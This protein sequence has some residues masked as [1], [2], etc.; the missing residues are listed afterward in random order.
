MRVD[1]N[2]A[3]RM[4]Q[5]ITYIEKSHVFYLQ[6][7]HISYIF[8]A[9]E[10]GHLRHFY[11]GEKLPAGEDLSFYFRDED[12]GFSGNFDGAKD[13]TASMDTAFLEYPT[14]EMGDYRRPAVL[15]IMPGGARRTDFTY[16]SYRILNE[17]PPLDGLPHVRCGETLEITLRDDAYDLELRLCYTV[18][19]DSDA[20]VRSAKLTNRSAVPV[21]IEKIS[22]FSL[23]FIDADFETI[24]LYGRPCCERMPVREKCAPGYHDFSS[25]FRGSS[26][27]YLNPFFALVRRETG[28]THGEA[29]GFALVYSGAF[30]LS[31]EL[32]TYGTLRVQGGVSDCD[33]SWLLKSGE[34][35]QTPEA[36]L[37][38][39]GEGL[40]GMSRA[41]HALWRN[42]LMPPRSL[43]RRRPVVANSW[44]AAYFDFDTEKLFTL[45]DAAAEC[46][47]DTF[48]LDDG[49][50]ESR[51]NDSGGLGDW[52]ADT[53]KLHGG[54][55]AIAVRCRERGLSFGL[56]FEPEMV[57]E[58]SRLYRAHP[59]WCLKNPRSGPV[60]GRNQLVLD[61]CNPAV[62][63]CIY[64][65]MTRAIDISGANY[66][67]WDMNRYL[68]DLYA[69]SLPPERQQ[70]VQHRYVL[71]VYSLAE[72]LLGRFP[73]LLIEGCSGGGGRFDAGMLF[74][75]AQIWTSDNTDAYERATIQYG[76]SLC[77]PPSAM[78]AH[79][80]ACPNHLT[81][82]T[83]PPAAR[84]AVASSCAFGYEL[85]LAALSREER[86]VLKRQTEAYRET[87]PLVL[88][89][90]MFRLAEMRRDGLFAVAL[91][92]AGK[93]KAYIA[94]ITGQAH[95]NPLQKRLKIIGLDDGRI[96]RIRETGALASGIALRTAG[97]LLPPLTEDYMPVILH[98]VA[99]E[100]KK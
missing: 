15:I 64:T 97:L 40:G 96:Y 9:D 14:A 62:V 4:E 35:F 39:S 7:K 54:L 75:C 69:P 5:M 10:Y 43:G 51:N 28:E 21:R 70:E 78:S 24:S 76:T 30:S 23:D 19:D 11:F 1:V 81:G 90:D 65:K 45:I 20:V 48:V 34:T 84:Y 46:G 53:R 73:D 85:D 38:W 56:W 42:R 87:E 29:Y 27:H 59:D 63:D 72:R 50:F 99:S 52:A 74:Y 77:Y 2:A 32:T 8:G 16:C 33:F 86:G 71:G 17:K 100:T 94:G 61:F 36:A 80:S 67:K 12:R 91:V 58:D 47:A 25:A 18:S 49:W 60:R 13:R 3:Y 6:G 22:S 41:F 89:G 79:V 68:A 57:S 88:E 92:S 66:I 26:S 44:E 83:T 55:E 31:T 98:L 95:A 82:R 93:D 37:V